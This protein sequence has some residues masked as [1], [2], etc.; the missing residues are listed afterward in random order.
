MALRQAQDREVT[1]EQEDRPR[2]C[3]E[4]GID[5]VMLALPPPDEW[6]K[7]KEDELTQCVESERGREVATKPCSRTK[8]GGTEG[9]QTVQTLQK[10]HTT[11]SA[12]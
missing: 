12:C 10:G 3:L 11:T 2:R 5:V 6:H 1:T 4:T 9:S 8:E 7:M